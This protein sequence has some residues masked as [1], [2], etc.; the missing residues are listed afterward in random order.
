MP[1]RPIEM[2]VTRLGGKAVSTVVPPR[3]VGILRQKNNGCEIQA[4]N[5]SA[6]VRVNDEHWRLLLMVVRALVHIHPSNSKQLAA[7]HTYLLRI[8][9]I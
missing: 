3:Q 4:S 8:M 6:V 9:I 5:T 2:Y 7:L 1:R